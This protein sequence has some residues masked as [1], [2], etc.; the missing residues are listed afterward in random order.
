MLTVWRHYSARFLGAFAAAF[1]ILA[2]LLI[3]VDAMLHLSALFDEGA[4]PAGA[5]RFVLERSAGTYAEFLIPI[6]AF[7]GSFWCAGGATLQREVLALKA[8][9][10][11]PLAAFTPL[12][13][14]ALA[15]AAVHGQLMERVATPAAAALAARR[16][17]TG[18]DV[19]VRGG[20]VWFH[21]GRVL[22]SVGSLD[23]SRGVVGEI[24][25]YERDASGQL[26]RTIH[27]RRGERLAPQRWAFENAL[28]REIDPAARSQPPRER[29]E[30]R[31][32]IEL[33]SDRSPQLRRDE[34]PGLPREQLRAYVTQRGDGPGA[35]EA[36]VALA[37]RE[38]G[39]WAVPLFAALAI[40]LALRSEERRS[41]A[42]AGAQ[43]AGLLIAFLLA[44]DV[45]SSFAASDPRLA[46]AFPWLT[47]A[48]LA[49]FG[50]AK[51]A[52]VGR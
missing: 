30:A 18:G 7:A 24:R 46:A 52:R 13:V 36:R 15:L 17:P 32:V 11:S 33:A 23:A 20:E 12:V 37:N 4:G 9:G 22:Y 48:A 39:P 27:A 38:S 35:G 34:L 25:V 5:L 44:R 26:V 14:L 31:I 43:G 28:V 41:L 8:S 45:G 2:L 49:A 6:A 16:H 29:R 51:L 10:I 50:L 47:L 19:R 21:A 40:P 42:R 3:A 1:A